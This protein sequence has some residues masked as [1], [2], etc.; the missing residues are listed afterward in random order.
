VA[1]GDQRLE[2]VVLHLPASLRDRAEAMANRECLSLNLFVLM[3]IAEKLQRLQLQHCLDTSERD[4]ASSP[5]D[6]FRS[7]V[8]H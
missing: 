5:E 3:A 1:F 8:V 4:E 2:D 7:S 6:S